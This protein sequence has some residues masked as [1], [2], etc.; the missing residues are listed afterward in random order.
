MSLASRETAEGR[1]QVQGQPG[2]QNQPGATVANLVRPYFKIQS[3]KTASR[4]GTE[5]RGRRG[6]IMR[7]LDSLSS[8]E[9]ENQEIM[10]TH[11]SYFWQLVP[12]MKY[13]G[14]SLTPTT[15]H[16]E[17]GPLIK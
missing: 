14:I 1:S 10:L 5:L 2:L 15:V 4:A 12:E 11:F 8:A 9:K 13:L 7:S 17:K 16:D 3:S 6:S